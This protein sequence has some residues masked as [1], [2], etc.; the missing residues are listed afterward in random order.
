MKYLTFSALYLLLLCAGFY[1]LII[2]GF[3]LFDFQAS[4][5]TTALLLETLLLIIIQ[6]FLYAITKRKRLALVLTT[7][8]Y[9]S[10]LCATYI[11]SKTL[12]VPIFPSD[13]ILIGDLVRTWDVF[14]IYV[15]FLLIFIGL[16]SLVCLIEM[17]RKK[18]EKV[19]SLGLLTMLTLAGVLLINYQNENIRLWLRA[20]GIFYKKNV[21]LVKKGVQNGF[22]LSFVQAA[23]FVGKPQPPNS[24]SLQSINNIIEKY[25][26]NETIGGES[27]VDNVIILMTES[28]T[29]PGDFGWEYSEEIIP[30]YRMMAS[31]HTSGHVISPVYGGRSI[32]AEFEIMTGMSNRFTPIETTPYQ[33]FIDTDITSLARTFR[34][35]GFETS[36]IQMVK[37]EGF[38]YSKIYQ[39]IGVDNKVSLS[40][41]NKGTEPDPSGRSVSS[42]ETAKE[43]LNLVEKQD[44]SFIFAFPNSTHS[45]WNLDHYPNSTLELMN[46][47]VNTQEKT[48]L[49]AYTNALNHVDGLFEKL[50]QT[51]S[52]S[53]EKTLLVVIGDHQPGMRF[54]GKNLTD[55][56]VY[57]KFINHTLNKYK[58]TFVAWSNYPL[59]DDSDIN[60]SMNLIPAFIINNTGLKAD[61]FMKFVVILKEH[62]DV[63]SQIYKLR[64]GDY[65]EQLPG[66]VKELIRDY[67]TLQY[68]ILFGKNYIYQLDVGNLPPKAKDN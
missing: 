48:R 64:E 63:I 19:Y 18:A 52:E 30:A 20:H 12:G 38:G 31:S 45:P 39:Y 44:K 16:V 56:P 13:F 22:L 5:S 21:N 33:E 46:E 37:F 4:I 11:K 66:H 59:D 34:R 51:F 9:F 8:F 47:N 15:P 25:K 35:N 1:F 6:L 57:S 36:A 42:D 67:K 49:L 3:G 14:V 53:T 65:I 10:F 41:K 2:N 32:N 17:K 58:T 26:L 62:F 40:S 68:D 61:G 29:D 54:F 7:L 24:Y 60:I 50:V 55:S 43:I 28:F 27:D 23:F